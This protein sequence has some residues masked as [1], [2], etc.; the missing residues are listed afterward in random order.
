[1][2]YN[3]T[4]NLAIT[5]L[6]KKINLVHLGIIMDG[7]RRWAREQGLTKLEGH[8]KGYDKVKEVT[9]WCLEA[10][11]KVLTV[12]A[13]STENWTRSQEEVNYLME[14][15]Y[16]AV[17][18]DAEDFYNKGVRVKIIGQKERLSRKLQKAISEIEAKTKEND[19]LLLQVAISYG[20]RAEIIEAIR[21]LAASGVKLEQV[22]KDQFEKYLWTA[23]TPDPDFIIRTSGEIRLSGFLIWQGVYSELYFPKVYWPAFSKQDFVKALE[24]FGKRKR[25]FGGGE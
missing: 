2:N 6:A 22:T 25:R 21:K 19:K 13:F 16:L 14:L 5:N 23:G 24:E 12:W 4:K 17:T 11:L 1:M 18:R 9:D 8:K 20:G 7:N 10:G 3:S 15:L